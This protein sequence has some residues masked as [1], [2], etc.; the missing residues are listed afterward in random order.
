M[1][2]KREVTESG[3]ALSRFSAGGNTVIILTPHPVRRAYAQPTVT[4]YGSMLALTRNGFGSRPENKDSE[5]RNKR[6]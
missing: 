3:A 2:S 6:S 4:N 1:R 5:T